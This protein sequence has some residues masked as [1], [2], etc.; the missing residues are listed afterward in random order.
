MDMVGVHAAACCALRDL[1][2]VGVHELLLSQCG[3]ESNNPRADA[4]VHKHLVSKGLLPFEKFVAADYSRLL[5]VI[6]VNAFHFE[7]HEYDGD[8]SSETSTQSEHV[9]KEFPQ[10][11]RGGLGKALFGRFAR[12]ANHSCQPNAWHSFSWNAHAAT[13]TLSII[14]EQA[15]DQDEEVLISYLSE[16]ELATMNVVE[17]R[18]KL[19]QWG[20]DCDCCRCA[21]ESLLHPEDV[22]DRVATPPLS[23]VEW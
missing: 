21:R 19:R 8:E 17:R 10:G 1:R 3:E 20:F 22:P 9:R 6:K 4:A 12:L 14:A 16:E 13:L 2:V 18:K 11:H 5:G 15:L 7:P 23:G